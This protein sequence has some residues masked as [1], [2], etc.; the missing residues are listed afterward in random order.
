MVKKFQSKL[1]KVAAAPLQAK[2][3]V[4]FGVM[5][6][7]CASFFKSIGKDAGAQS[8]IGLSVRSFDGAF[9]STHE[10]YYSGFNRLVMRMPTPNVFLSMPVI[11]QPIQPAV[12]TIKVELKDAPEYSDHYAALVIALKGIVGDGAVVYENLENGIRSFSADFPEEVKKHEQAKAG[13]DARMWKDLNEGYKEWCKQY[14]NEY[15]SMKARH[16]AIASGAT[17][18]AHHNN[19]TKQLLAKAI[20]AAFANKPSITKKEFILMMHP[21]KVTQLNIKEPD[22]TELVTALYIKVY[23]EFSRVQ[24]FPVEDLKKALA[25]L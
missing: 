1:A 21:D 15:I 8:Y 9:G 5:D 25:G 19:V 18:G 11:K 20:D 14:D 6:D 2:L 23:P 10:A 22:L 16:A 3:R 7:V 12:K 4:V 13:F 24:A 17:A